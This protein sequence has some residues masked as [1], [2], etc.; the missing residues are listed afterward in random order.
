MTYK[1][2]SE[3]IERHSEWFVY[4][5]YNA[6]TAGKAGSPESCERQTVAAA[7]HASILTELRAMRIDLIGGL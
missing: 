4:H 6:E 2:V 3:A 5:M 1:E 7:N